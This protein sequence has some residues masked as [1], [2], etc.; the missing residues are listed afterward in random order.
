[1][2]LGLE[3]RA[4]AKIKVRQP[5]QKAVIKEALGEEIATIVR[6]EL[7]VKEIVADATQGELITLD[8][9][10]TGALKQEGE[11]RELLRAV[12][13][14]RKKKGLKPGEKAV[15]IV[16]TSV[17]GRTQVEESKPVLMKSA[18]LSGIEY[19]S[20]SG[21]ALTLEGFEVRMRLK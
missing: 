2:S 6:D 16:G 13:E 17:T 21:D 1:M 4:N 20:V 12:Q 10:L 8:M 9:T 18:A 7:N 3:L 15:L 14:L 19:D 5:L 11:T